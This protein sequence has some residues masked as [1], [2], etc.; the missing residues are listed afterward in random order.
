MNGAIV[1]SPI[2]Q[3]LE[4]KRNKIKKIL[5]RMVLNRINNLLLI[6]IILCST[7]VY[8][9]TFIGPLQKV[10]ELLGVGLIILLLALHAAY[11]ERKPLPQNFALPVILILLSLVTSMFMAN[12]SR[13][14]DFG[15]TLYAQRAIYYYLLYFLIHQLRIKPGDLEIMFIGF[16][17]LYVIFFFIQF[18]LFPRIIFDAYIRF[19]RGTIRIYLAGSG[20]LAI[21]IYMF[22]QKFFR[23]N[24]IKYLAM[25]LLLLPVIILTGGRQTMAIMIFTMIL[26]VITDRKIKSRLSLIALGLV[27]SF[28]LYIMFQG[29][30]EALVVQSRN[31]ARLGEDY[32][33]FRAAEFFL[34]EFFLN[35]VAYITGNGMYANHTA[36]G[37]EIG[38]YMMN[39]RYY[40]GDIGI[41][42]NYVL[43]GSLFLAGVIIIII[44]ILKIRIESRFT[45]I[46]F[47]TIDLMLSILTGG[48]FAQAHFIALYVTVLY[49]ADISNYQ[50]KL[51]TANML[52]P[53]QNNNKK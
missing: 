24:N 51:S 9:I 30:F 44:R 14:Q 6:F 38:S 23:T 46:K 41:I 49:L 2:Y 22:A 5:P 43:Y 42:G 17:F 26:F 8:E 13:D 45:Y 12:Y 21:A 31:D 27:A 52:K 18:Y 3:L 28:M 35:P 33:R 15:N 34:T 53:V 50:L 10:S 16:G 1:T 20:Y 37:N 4:R 11:G 25:L 39:K 7:A 48:S 36:Y 47:L 29:I 19:E 32:I 40:L